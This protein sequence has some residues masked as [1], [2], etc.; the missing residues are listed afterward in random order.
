MLSVLPRKI[1]SEVD[2]T[3][4]WFKIRKVFILFYLRSG[5]RKTKMV[6]VKAQEK[7]ALILQCLL[8]LQMFLLMENSS[9]SG[10]LFLQLQILGM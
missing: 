7:T 2:S 5:K 6:Q 10:E 8:S 1:S 4:I 9:P 3:N